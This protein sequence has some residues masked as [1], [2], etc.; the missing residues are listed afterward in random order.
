M[1]Y[2]SAYTGSQVDAAVGA[3]RQK[4]TKWDNK[5]DELTGTE[6]QL[7]GFNSAGE[8][9]A[10]PKPTAADV[11]AMPAVSGGTTGQVLTKGDGETVEWSDPS[12]GLPTGGTPGQMLYQGESGPEWG[13]K[14]VMYV[15]ITMSGA[16]G[17]ADK[18]VAEIQEA[19]SN[20]TIVV[21]C[22]NGELYFQ[23]GAISGSSVTFISTSQ[24]KALVSLTWSDP[25]AVVPNSV[26]IPTKASN[27]SFAKAGTGLN[28]KN[29][30]AAIEE[31]NEKIPSAPKSVSVT[32]T[33]SAWSSNT[34]TV[35]VSGVLADESA[36]LIQPMPAIAS[37][38]AYITA[39]VICSGQAANQLTFTCT[40]VPTEDLSVYVVIQGVSA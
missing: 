19:V 31:V 16:T 40:T 2:N 38:N 34:Q 22:L 13:D 30:Q 28:S 10:V 35:T 11:G 8:A 7:V 29:V 20:G 3:V 14:P 37:Q 6:D 17:T 15:T 24:D 5:Q 25:S 39:G 9:T 18:T 32:L 4:E 21:A 27:L 36:Q 1:A 26:E 23:L 33:T 12:S